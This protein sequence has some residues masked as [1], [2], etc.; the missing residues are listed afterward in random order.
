MLPKLPRFYRF[1]LP[2]I[3]IYPF[4]FG[5]LVMRDMDK[6]IFLSF[7]FFE[8]YLLATGVLMGVVTFVSTPKAKVGGIFS[9]VMILLKSI[10][11]TGFLEVCVLGVG[12]VVA[13]IP[14]LI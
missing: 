1:I 9:L 7:S 11:W 10:P 12:F 6:S 5:V 4:A 8:A 2:A 3:L 14:R 13:M